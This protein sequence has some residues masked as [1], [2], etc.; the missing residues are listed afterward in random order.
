MDDYSD[1]DVILGYN[2]PEPAISVKIAKAYPK[3]LDMWDVGDVAVLRVA[4]KNP[5]LKFLAR[6]PAHLQRAHQADKTPRV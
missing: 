3:W 6:N 5:I 1:A 2:S 4:Q